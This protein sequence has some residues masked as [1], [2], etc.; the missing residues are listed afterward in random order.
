[1]TSLRE[2]EMKTVKGL[3]GGLAGLTLAGI[4]GLGL[5]ALAIVASLPA[6]AQSQGP[7]ALTGKVTSQEEGAMEGVVVSAKRPGSTIMVSVASNA[8]GQ[9]AFPK[10]RLEPGAYD[11]TMRAIGYVLA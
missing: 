2:G 5:A 4:L 3:E 8:Q 6:L 9:Y 1:M 11:I 7:A 10:D